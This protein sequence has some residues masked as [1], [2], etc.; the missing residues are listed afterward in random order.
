[1]LRHAGNFLWMTRQS[2][3][4]TFSKRPDSQTKQTTIKN[5]LVEIR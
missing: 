2:N 1:M 3:R 5:R 4:A